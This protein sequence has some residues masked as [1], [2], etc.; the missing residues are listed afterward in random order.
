MLGQKLGQILENLGVRSRGQIFSP[1]IM[2]HGQNVFL[3]EISD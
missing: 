3:D 1:I 2:K